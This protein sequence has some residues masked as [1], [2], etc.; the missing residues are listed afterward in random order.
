VTAVFG[1]L[2]PEFQSSISAKFNVPELLT[3][4][5][6]TCMVIVHGVS[7]HLN[8]TVGSSRYDNDYNKLL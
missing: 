4:G 6:S 8:V 1:S 3:D 2:D 5:G 7:W